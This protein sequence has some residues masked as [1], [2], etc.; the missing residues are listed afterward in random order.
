VAHPLLVCSSAAAEDAVGEDPL[1]GF[2]VQ[3]IELVIGDGRFSFR[4][5]EVSSVMVDSV[6]PRSILAVLSSCLGTQRQGRPVEGA[7]E[8][9]VLFPYFC[10]REGLCDGIP[11]SGVGGGWWVAG[12]TVLRPAAPNL[13]L[14]LL[15]RAPTLKLLMFFQGFRCVLSVV[16]RCWLLQLNKVW[17]SSFKLGEELILRTAILIINGV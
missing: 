7:P 5:P 17:A 10:E 9:F 2:C 1:L 13:G 14:F 15:L 12:S 4:S 6:L 11:S 3:L 8:S 16:L